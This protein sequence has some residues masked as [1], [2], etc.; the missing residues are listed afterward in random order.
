MNDFGFH[1]PGS[2]AEAVEALRG[3]ADRKL[4]AGGQSL[5]PILKLGLAQPAALV[6]LQGVP[7]L[8]GIQLNGGELIVGAA[9]S[10]AEV[11]TS[12][13]VLEAIPALA[14]LADRIGDAQVRN[15][16]TI[17]GSLAHSDPAAD[18]PAALLGLGATVVTDRRTISAD[19]FFK[20]MF[21]TALATDEIITSV[22]F[23]TPAKATYAKMP[24]PA[25]RF[26]IVGVFVARAKDGAVRVGVTGAAATPFRA[27]GLE[28]ALSRSFAPEAVDGVAVP[29]DDL[30]SDLHASA[31]YRAHLVT[32][33]ARR[34]VAALA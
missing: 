27:R 24:N 33:M 22:R 1:R 3:G 7:E 12:P 34:A 32:V 28:E 23:P 2:L 13:I 9:S 29:E 4:L 31:A 5:I 10:H 25:S 26:A 19:D 21:E 30:V 18:Y 14:H 16:G 15:R 8:R 6:S 11:A 17:G 20:G